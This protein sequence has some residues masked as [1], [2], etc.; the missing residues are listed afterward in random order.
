MNHKTVMNH[1]AIM[2]HKAVMNHKLAK[3]LTFTMIGLPGFALAL[4]TDT[5]TAVVTP[6]IGG[7]YGFYHMT[8]DSDLTDLDEF[9]DDNTAWKAFVGGGLN[10]NFGLEIAHVDFKD[11]KKSQ[12]EQKVEGQ[13]I[14]AVIGW[15]IL[16]SMRLY[17][18]VGQF[19]WDTEVGFNN[20][21]VD[22]DGDDTFFGAGLQLG[23]TPG[24]NL[25]LEYERYKVDE[26]DIDLPS[27]SAIISF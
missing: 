15:P 8:D 20:V 9:K 23:I 1:K 16:D 17:G 26:T 21:K 14:A 4:E 12:W 5:E 25:R 19:F 6:Y 7:S 22:D 11:A 13:S 2:N 27:I 24:L 10:R 18:K 3:A